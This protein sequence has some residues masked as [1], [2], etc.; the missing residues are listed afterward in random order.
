MGAGFGGL[1][2]SHPKVLSITE[3]TDA[4]L[5]SALVWHVVPAGTTRLLLFFAQGNRNPSLGLSSAVYGA[6]TDNP[7]PLTKLAA[8]PDGQAR[9]ELWMLRNP[10]EGAAD[11]QIDAQHP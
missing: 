4:N 10:P 9:V 2:V 8:T 11:L 5:V 1:S 7:Q 6:G 3:F